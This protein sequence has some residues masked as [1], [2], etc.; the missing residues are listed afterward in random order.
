[1]ATRVPPPPITPED[2]ERA[3]L[4]LLDWL[5]W[6]MRT[7]PKDAGTKQDLANI[8]GVSRT[9]VSLL[10]RPQSTRAPSFETILAVS[11]VL[12]LPFETITSKPAPK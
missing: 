7:H 12:G 5:R 6:Y 3:R 8:L 11:R 4:N 1:M 9:A 10:L 2:V